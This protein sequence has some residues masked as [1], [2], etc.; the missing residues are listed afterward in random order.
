MFDF[1]SALEGPRDTG[2]GSL[3]K[4]ISITAEC[5]QPPQIPCP[6]PWQRVPVAPVPGLRRQPKIWKRVGGLVAAPSESNYVDAMAELEQQGHGPR[7]RTRPARHVPRYGDARWDPRVEQERDGQQDLVEAR[8]TVSAAKQ[9]VE[10]V[11][12]DTTT[13][14]TT[15]PED[16]L[17]WIPRKRHNTR[18]PIEPR[19]EKTPRMVADMQPLIKFE[20]P[21]APEPAEA[22]VQIDDEQMLRRSTRRLSRRFSLLPGEDSPRKL[23]TVTLSPVKKPAPALSPVKR[24]PVTL[25]P[26]KVVDSPLRSF[27]VNAT[28]TKVVL[29]SPRNSPPVMSPSKQ[30][31][32][33]MAPTEDAALTPAAKVVQRDPLDTPT[34]AIPL[35]FDQ[36][37]PEL[38]EESQHEARRRLSL[39]AARRT[40]RGSSGLSRLLALKS[41]GDSSNRRHSFA[42][43][44]NLPASGQGHTKGRR[45]TMD[46][47]CVGP[48]Q[49]IM[50]DAGA[51]PKA[52]E[53][54]E[55]DMKTNLDIFGQPVKAAGSPCCAVS[56]VEQNEETSPGTG[57][58]AS[59]NDPVS[60]DVT[61]RSPSTDTSDASEQTGLEVG[62][63][64][65]RQ[66]TTSP[67]ANQADGEGHDI[68]VPAPRTSEEESIFGEAE[69][70]EVMFVPHDPEGLSTIYEELSVVEDRPSD[71]VDVEESAGDATR[72]DS[73]R[74]LTGEEP[75]SG[76][77]TP[78]FDGTC[79]D[80]V[81]GAS[82]AL[83]PSDPP[84]HDLQA[85]LISNG[86]QP[87]SKPKIDDNK[88]LV[89]FEPSTVPSANPDLCGTLSQNPENERMAIPHEEHEE[90]EVELLPQVESDAVITAEHPSSPAL[91]R[92]V[93]DSPT[94]AVASPEAV[95]GTPATDALAEQTNPQAVAAI[96]AVEEC[97]GFTPINGRQVTPPNVLPSRLQDEEDQAHPESDE[98]DADQVIDED[99]PVDA[100]EEA[101][102]ASD[103]DDLTVNPPLPAND[104]LQLQGRHDDSETEMLRKFVTRVTADKNAK[105]AAAAAALASK[106]T[107]ASRRSSST[108][109]TGPPM[110][111]SDSETRKPLGERSPNSSP[112]KT[113]KRKLDLL[114][115]DLPKANHT[116]QEPPDPT[117]VNTDAPRLKRRRS[118][119]TNPVLSTSTPS[120][121]PEPD[122]LHSSSTPAPR[123]SAR[124]RSTRVPLRPTGPSANSVALSLIPVR[125][126]GMGALADDAA[127]EAHLSAMAR[128]RSAEKDLAS[129][130]R[131]NTR[132]NKGGAV[133]PQ[134]VLARQQEDQGWRMRELKGVFDAKRRREE[135]GENRNG[136]SGDGPKKG[137]KWAEE[138]VR[139]QVLEAD[140]EP[141]SYVVMGEGVDGDR[142]GI[143]G[144]VDEIAEAEPIVGDGIK[145]GRAARVVARR[146]TTEKASAAATSAAAATTRRTRSSLPTLLSMLKEIREKSADKTAA[147]PAAKAVPAAGLRTR[148]RS[149]PK[150]AAVPA[151][152]DASSSTDAPAPKSAASTS[153]T[154]SGMAT[155]RT[156]VT[157]LGMSGNGTPAP[158]RRGRTAS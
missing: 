80:H 54:L 52:E 126:P 144:G 75:A 21:V 83:S 64:S 37:T 114:E 131:S 110:V 157:K 23:S 12:I 20:V 135:D 138:L 35:L 3:F 137:V 72:D 134:V 48:D 78:R 92:Q 65:S 28:P 44:Q 30:S 101:A 119:R 15:F 47:L 57:S 81:V 118:K 136:S 41:G 151:P 94:R 107:R 56:P 117:S 82:T 106:I 22:A 139:Y 42:S 63:A 74:T 55:I 129:L 108:T 19:K 103:E 4:Q 13:R 89:A 76:P 140:G 109:S 145:V 46:G 2:P 61:S 33:S 128:Q 27:R 112:A 156:K 71:N 132:K 111:T 62:D 29:E 24:P 95:P 127:M 25:S 88:P 152:T 9:E 6:R 133:P 86:Q 121:A 91:D 124:T 45:N 142:D 53:V 146:A 49:D 123:R 68:W 7:K 26:T 104:T 38:A 79:A 87:S 90:M 36:P 5:F 1:T 102:R 10:A 153:S 18:W 96:D 99:L 51:S 59:S 147:A 158:K 60:P 73:S 97:S 116:T 150:L 77:E 39:Q 14:P 93:S 43:L 67:D 31:S 34:S 70:S 154:R 115:D 122:S 58:P 17:K 141:L 105:A 8:A 100:E 32:S 149:L 148:A 50:S 11:S 16:T 125:L 66:A 113:K 143:M 98:L 85:P 130:T 120:P 40:E 155:R 69:E 84:R